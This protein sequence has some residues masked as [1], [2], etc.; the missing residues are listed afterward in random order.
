VIARAT[1]QEVKVPEP[2]RYPENVST[3]QR[4]LGERHARFAELRE[5]FLADYGYNTARAYWAD[6][7]DLLDWA[8]EREKDVLNLTERD[9]TLYF[10]RMRRRGYSENTIRRRTT[11]FRGFFRHINGAAPTTGMA[12]RVERR[13]TTPRKAAGP[14]EGG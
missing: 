2:A 1:P 10:A 8:V 13:R 5:D 6:L 9:F 14:S 12:P 11:A 4:E 3:F 7:E